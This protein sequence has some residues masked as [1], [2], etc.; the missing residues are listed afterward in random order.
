MIKR[1]GLVGL[2]PAILGL[3]RGIDLGGEIANETHGLHVGQGLKVHPDFAA[4]VSL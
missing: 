3:W 1:H 4:P 2:I